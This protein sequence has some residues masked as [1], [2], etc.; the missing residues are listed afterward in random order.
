MPILIPLGCLEKDL[1]VLVV[2]KDRLL[3]IATIHDVVN[4]SGKLNPRRSRHEF[5]YTLPRKEMS[6]TMASK[7][8]LTPFDEGHET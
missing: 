3:V 7:L 8:G 4:G 5:K 1:P 2:P 6:M